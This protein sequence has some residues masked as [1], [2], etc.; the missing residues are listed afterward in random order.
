MAPRGTPTAISILAP[1]ERPATV[2]SA[3]N[4]L[5]SG[6]TAVVDDGRDFVV[7][8]KSVSLQTTCTMG[9]LT[10]RAEHW[11]LYTDCGGIADDG[12]TRRGQKPA[13]FTEPR[14]AR[15]ASVDEEVF[16]KHPAAVSPAYSVIGS[17]SASP[18]PSPSSPIVVE[19]ALAVWI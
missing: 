15:I 11:D 19:Q 1:S 9:I 5:V 18:S 17:R 6:V 3:V 4:V 14:H 16:R 2:V 7:A 10:V 12:P 8:G 13:A